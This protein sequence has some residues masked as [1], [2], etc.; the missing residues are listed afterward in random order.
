MNIYYSKN[1]VKR[2]LLGRRYQT[3]DVL[4][5][6]EGMFVLKMPISFVA[7][8]THL[9]GALGQLAGYLLQNR[10]SD[11]ARRLW[12]DANGALIS[13]AYRDRAEQFV[14][15]TMIL[16]CISFQKN[17]LGKE[18]IIIKNN[19]TEFPLQNKP[20]DIIMFIQFISSL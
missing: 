11:K 18:Y 8:F 7:N 16:P 9:F 4:I 2:G 20:A 5:T 12:L 15:R 14:P 17:W 1:W 13:E 10:V 6:A 3:Y 19:G